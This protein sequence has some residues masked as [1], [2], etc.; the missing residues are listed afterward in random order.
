MFCPKCKSEYRQ[1]FY[2]CADCG[3]EL[4]DRLP[5][6]P[7]DE[8]GDEE[9]VEVFS[10]YNQG[11]VAFIKSVLEGEGVTYYFQGDNP[12]MLIAAGAYAR[13]LVKS[14]EA[15]RAREILRD[16]GLL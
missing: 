4:V 2:Q 7:A 13:L 15:E 10:T 5:A 6:E 8:K 3:V 16:L 11:E 12:V 14:D 9:F 1:G